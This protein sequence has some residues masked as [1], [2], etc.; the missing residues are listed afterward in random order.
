MGSPGRGPCCVGLSGLCSQCVVSRRRLQHRGPSSIAA[1]RQAELVRRLPRK[2]RWVYRASA[3]PTKALG[4][5]WVIESRV[6]RGTVGIEEPDDSPTFKVLFAA[7]AD[8][9]TNRN[10]K[11]DRSR[12]LRHVVPKFARMRLAEITPTVTPIQHQKING[13]DL[14]ATQPAVGPDATHH[15]G[16][17][18]DGRGH[19]LHRG[20]DADAA[21]GADIT[22]DAVATYYTSRRR[23]G[24]RAR[25][26]HRRTAASNRIRCRPGL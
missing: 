21:A 15:L 1:R 2:R 26:V 4:K 5:R 6:A 16:C 13:L 7:F 20:I 9:L 25:V 23:T 11:D 24:S 17:A 10:A 18:D 8:G 3:Q 22:L 19:H 14:N 12:G